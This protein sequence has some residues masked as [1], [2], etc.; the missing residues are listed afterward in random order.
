MADSLAV[1]EAVGQPV[2]HSITNG[3]ALGGQEPASRSRTAP[4]SAQA[5]PDSD[6]T[7]APPSATPS[8]NGAYLRTRLPLATGLLM[9]EMYCFQRL[10][11][12][13]MVGPSHAERTAANDQA[14]DQT[15]R[16]LNPAP[17]DQ[18]PG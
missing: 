3:K 2:L 14:H 11:S 13:V 15:A 7:S 1:G 12:G 8:T 18:G 9:L 17:I 4:K 5:T 16:T 6:T 10:T